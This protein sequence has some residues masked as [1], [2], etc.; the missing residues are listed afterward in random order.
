MTLKHWFGLALLVGCG[1]DEGDS[2]SA[3]DSPSGFVQI[4][5]C[6][7]TPSCAFSTCHGGASGS[8]GLVLND[9][10]ACGEL[11]GVASSQQATMARV[12]AGAATESYLYLKLIGSAIITGDQMPPPS[13][14]RPRHRFR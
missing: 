12:E 7:F 5:S 1:G 8:A 10:A 3:C 13:G 2:S 9:G 11:V 14:G 6:I 4:E